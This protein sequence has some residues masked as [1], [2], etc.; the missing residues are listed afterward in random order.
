M[1]EVIVDDGL[2]LDVIALGQFFQIEFLGS[3]IDDIVGAAAEGQEGSAAE[4]VHVGIGIHGSELHLDEAVGPG[5]FN[6]QGR[7]EAPFRFIHQPEPFMTTAVLNSLNKLMR[8]E[9]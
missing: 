2:G 1:A 4:T 3:P 9:P 5:L 6:V 7:T 8:R